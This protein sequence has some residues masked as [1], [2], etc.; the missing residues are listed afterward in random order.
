[1]IHRLKWCHDVVNLVLML[2]RGLYGVDNVPNYIMSHDPKQEQSP[3]DH[4]IFHSSD[5]VVCA[6]RKIQNSAWLLV[7]SVSDLFCVQNN[8]AGSRSLPIAQRSVPPPPSDQSP[9]LPRCP[10]LEPVLHRHAPSGD[11]IMDPNRQPP[12]YPHGHHHYD[13]LNF[14]IPEHQAN[15]PNAWP[16]NYAP[17]SI[18]IPPTSIASNPHAPWTA[19][20]PLIPQYLE[21]DVGQAPPQ[22]HLFQQQAFSTPSPAA[23]HTPLSDSYLL[24][25]AAPSPYAYHASPNL[26]AHPSPVPRSMSASALSNIPAPQQQ[27][28]HP[29]Q[30]TPSSTFLPTPRQIRFVSSDGQPHTKRRRINAACLT[31]RKR[32]TRCSGERPECKTC[33]DNGHVCAGYADR[34]LKKD[35]EKRSN[36]GDEDD[37]DASG[38]SSPRRPGFEH[39]TSSGRP[40][41]AASGGAFDKQH[42]YDSG[43]RHR[44]AAQDSV[45]DT[46]SPTSSYTAGSTGA[47]T[48]RTRVPYFRYFGPTAIVPGFKQMV[49]QMKD[50]REQRRSH[51]SVQGDSPAPGGQGESTSVS[52]RELSPVPVDLPYYDANDPNPNPQLI[53]QLC[54]AFFTN[55]GCNYPFLQRQRFLQDLDDKKVDA[56]LVNAVCAV[57]ARFSEEPILAKSDL[58]LPLD[59]AGEVKRAFRGQ[60]FAQRAM[61][62]VVD[63]FSCPTL[64][65]T[66]ACLLLAYEEFGS[67]RDSGLWMYLGTS[68]RMA[69]DLGI[70]KLEGLQLEG[71]LG[72]TPKTAKNGSQGK[73]E[74][75]RRTEQ[76]SRLS[77]SLRDE[78]SRLLE[79]RRASERE[80]I[81]TFWAIFFLD[82]AVS[83]GVG[84]PVTLRD[85]DIEIS[86]PYRLNE[87]VASGHPHP[88]PAMIKVVH[89]YGR[90]ADVLNNIKDVTQV[91]E[92]VLKRLAGMEKDLT[93]L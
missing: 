85:K 29:A 12:R 68:I 27:S 36:D 9:Q 87:K 71:R 42:S 56:I 26:Y 48:G 25:H 38:S 84:R 79:D 5:P 83:S 2:A 90:V 75:A 21:T 74:E 32:K 46:K 33:T 57:A 37:E 77:R 50:H 3:R 15:D 1:M 22:H 61:S 58:S 63:T 28:Q 86:F 76:Q 4:R 35:L 47:V 55:L 93:G 7:V 66:Q 13:H 8:K 69:Q 80:R 30:P 19:S 44:Q 31:C 81:D 62:A 59:H 72:P 6:C 67:D 78:D 10:T 14:D 92:D 51:T 91:T 70:Q 16:A 20:L 73:E 17:T 11:P 49:V 39:G 34:V 24:T 60:P 82:R 53:T 23:F 64:A 54:E 89:M 40:G 45:P 65:V 43:S 52:G 88:F 41:P 18:S